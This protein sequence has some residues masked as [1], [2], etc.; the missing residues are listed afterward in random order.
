MIDIREKSQCCGCTACVNACPRQCI[1]MRRDRKEGFDY[2]VANPDLCIGCGKCEE[3]CP[4]LN[5]RQETEPLEAFAARSRRFIDGSSSGGVF[6]L[7]AAG[8]VSRGGAVFGA[9]SDGQDEV[10]HRMAESIEE[11]EGM[12]GS[13]YVQSELF[14][15]FEDVRSCLE[16]GREVLFTG[17]PCQVAGLKNWLGK[18]DDSEKERFLI[19]MYQLLSAS[20]AETLSE[21]SEDRIN[22]ALSLGKT[23][24]S[25]DKET[26]DLVSRAVLLFLR[27]RRTVLKKTKDAEK[28]FKKSKKTPG[29]EDDSSSPDGVS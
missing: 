20:G 3:V 2:P 28:Q 24:L 7:V 25:F 4:V 19:A 16:A 29:K 5:P 13:K 22:S 11:V 12:R 26:R 10:S 17:L 8:V 14:A 23:L 1:V 9:A 27:E 21:I 15:A 18:I 6:P